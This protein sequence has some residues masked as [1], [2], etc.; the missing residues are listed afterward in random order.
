[1]GF[2]FGSKVEGTDHAIAARD[3]HR[4]L[5]NQALNLKPQ[6]KRGL[7]GFVGEFQEF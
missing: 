5:A 2:F 6:V 3:G 1:M 7:L 4:A